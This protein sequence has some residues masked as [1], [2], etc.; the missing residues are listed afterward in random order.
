MRLAVTDETA[1]CIFEID[2]V[3]NVLHQSAQKTTLQGQLR[4]P[5][6]ALRDVMCNP[7]QSSVRE[8]SRAHLNGEYRLVLPFHRP[9]ES[10]SSARLDFLVTPSGHVT[11]L[12]R[13]G[14]Q[15][16]FPE[17]FF[18]RVSQHFTNLGV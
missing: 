15:N 11:Q 7:L 16:A 9:L 8:P 3:R 1:I 4:L 10:H 12:I 14:I 5:A 18:L 6:F 2:F 17:Q 13:V